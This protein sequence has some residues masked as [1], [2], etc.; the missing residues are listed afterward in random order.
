MTMTPVEARA[1]LTACNVPIGENFFALSSSTVV[2]L[3]AH[4]DKHRYRHPKNAN[5]SRGRYWHDR[6]QRIA[7]R[8]LHKPTPPPAKAMVA[9]VH[10]FGDTVAVYVGKGATTYLSGADARKLARALNRCAKSIAAESFVD[11]HCG[12]FELLE[13]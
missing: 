5:G 3:L 8:G 7:A 2:D 9:Q 6:L 4:A 12:T 13:K 11:S 1:V 10:R